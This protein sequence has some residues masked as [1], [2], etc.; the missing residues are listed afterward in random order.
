MVNYVQEACCRSNRQ[1]YW[2]V[3]LHTDLPRLVL[4][5]PWVFF[6][7][8]KQLYQ[9]KFFSNWDLHNTDHLNRGLCVEMFCPHRSWWSNMLCNCQSPERPPTEAGCLSPVSYGS[10]MNKPSQCEVVCINNRREACEGKRKE[11]VWDTDHIISGA[12]AKIW[13]VSLELGNRWFSHKFQMNR[14]SVTF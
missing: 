13:E 3:L 12:S 9:Y 6:F 7:F 4:K 5:N 11:S 8:F 2:S 1:R 10:L 14:N